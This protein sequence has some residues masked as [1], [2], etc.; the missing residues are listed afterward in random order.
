MVIIIFGTSIALS[1]MNIAAT[2]ITMRAPGMTWGRLPIDRLGLAVLDRARPARVPVVRAR[3]CSSLCDRVFGTSFYQANMGG[4]N[5]LYEELFWFM[6]HPEVY[7]ILL[8]G[9]G[10]VCEIVPTFTRKPLFGYKLVV[11]AEAAIFIISLGVWMH[12]LYWSGANTAL[13]TPMMLEHRDHLDPDRP[14]LPRADRDDVARRIRFEPPMLFA[15]G[16]H[17]ST[18]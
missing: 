2:V 5:W 18:S 14:D 7:V 6:G 17:A 1:A 8:P 11:A 13:D 16:V 4:N 12:H 9:V 3:G 10:A 15:L